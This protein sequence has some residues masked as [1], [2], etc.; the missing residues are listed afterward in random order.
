MAPKK[1]RFEAY[2]P[3]SW[4]GTGLRVF[5]G[6]V[7]V[8]ALTQ[9]GFGGQYPSSFIIQLLVD[10]A[11]LILNVAMVVPRVLERE[12]HELVVQVFS[13]LVGAFFLVVLLLSPYPDTAP[14][15]FVFAALMLLSDCVRVMFL[16]LVDKYEIFKLNKTH[17]LAITLLDAFLNFVVVLLQVFHY[18]F[19]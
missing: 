12:I 5:G 9:I 14:F 16:L 10:L 17:A 4:I 3:L 6:I 15:I 19:N 13:A 7:A 1:W 11:L 2:G 18:V 8:A